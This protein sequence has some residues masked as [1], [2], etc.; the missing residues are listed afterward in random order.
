MVTKMNTR[1]LGI[2]IV[3]FLIIIGVAVVSFCM[4]RKY[5]EVIV[6]TTTT[7]TPLSL[8]EAIKKIFQSDL[9]KAMRNSKHLMYLSDTLSF[10][11][12]EVNKYY[13]FC[14]A[15]LKL[16]NATNLYGLTGALK[17]PGYFINGLTLIQPYKKFVLIINVSTA[18][19]SDYT[20]ELVL[21]NTQTG[22]QFS[23]GIL[24]NRTTIAYIN[25]TNPDDYGNYK[26]Y[27]YGWIKTYST[28]ASISYN[29]DLRAWIEKQ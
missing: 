5:S 1:N 22:E 21:V 9:E 27:L 18:G 14:D 24:H 7:T 11:N 12:L 20:L 3:F 4:G 25:I 13:V 29:I 28:K 23:Y 17:Y 10:D 2:I 15:G 16:Y 8:N 19:I 6:K 26:I